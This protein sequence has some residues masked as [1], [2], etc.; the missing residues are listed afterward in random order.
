MKESNISRAI[1]KDLRSMGCFCFKHWSGRFAKRGVS[2]ILGCLP[3]GRFIA[4]EVKAERGGRVS[5]Y[6]ERFIKDVNRCGGLGFIARSVEE[7]RER[8]AGV[9]VKPK[10]RGLF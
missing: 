10:Q 1:V 2:D 4:I 5:E 9:G 7:V 3:D 6:Q 8:L